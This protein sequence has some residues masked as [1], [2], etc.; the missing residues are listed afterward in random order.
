M[1]EQS[2]HLLAYLLGVGVKSFT[3]LTRESSVLM[4]REVTTNAA[5]D[6]TKNGLNATV[7][8]AAPRKFTGFVF[9]RASRAVRAVVW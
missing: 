7:F 3:F 5:A 1:L 8:R 6:S 9:F 2:R 4:M